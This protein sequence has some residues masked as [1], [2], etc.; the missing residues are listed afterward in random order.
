[1]QSYDKLN[2][3]VKVV[4]TLISHSQI[5]SCAE[6]EVKKKD[7]IAEEDMGDVKSCEVNYVWVAAF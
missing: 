1:M 4:N 2:V 6:K 5:R 3:F 7:D